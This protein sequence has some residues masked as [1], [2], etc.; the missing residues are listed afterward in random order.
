MDNLNEV[1]EI[2]NKKYMDLLTSN[3]RDYKEINK[4]FNVLKETNEDKFNEI[5]NIICNKIEFCENYMES[6]KNLLILGTDFAFKSIITEIRDIYMDY[7][8]IKNK[9]DIEKIKTSL[10]FPENSLFINIGVS[11]N[12]FFGIVI[13]NIFVCFERDEINLHSSYI[14]MMNYLNFFSIIISIL[15]F[16][17]IVFFVFIYISQFSEP[18]KEATYRINCSFFHIKDYSLTLYRKFDSNYPK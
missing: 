1:Y 3:I 18:I 14:N 4:L 16:L 17:F 13:K 12:D 9:E 5:K 2:E 11:L 15:I 6:N 10:F 8:K 7:K